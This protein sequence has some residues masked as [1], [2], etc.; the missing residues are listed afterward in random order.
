MSRQHGALAARL[1]QKAEALIEHAVKRQRGDAA[2]SHA[3]VAEQEG[4]PAPGQQDQQRLFKAGVV[5][6]QVCQVG[7]M[8]AVA[9]DE[10]GV[11]IGVA[12]AGHGGVDARQIGLRRDKGLD[13]R[14]S[15]FGQA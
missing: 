7:E 6:G 8:F 15:K 10:Q 12:G 14:Q 2:V 4:R 11:V 13:R 9:I 3:L 1:T 5:T